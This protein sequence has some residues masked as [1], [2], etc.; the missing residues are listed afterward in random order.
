MN[1]KSSLTFGRDKRLRQSA[2]FARI[3]SEGRRLA[4]GCLLANW[5]EN[6]G[7]HGQPLRLGVVTPKSVGPAPDRSRA[8]RLMREAFRLN[9]QRL[10]QPLSLVLVAR[11]SI[12]GNG[13]AEVE[14]DFL[15][16]MRAARL[17]TEE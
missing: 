5:V 16:L 2:E 17:L 6:G 4:K 10:K 7:R 9:Q 8:R 3:K 13:L 11:Q 12:V 15:N 1:D 14:R